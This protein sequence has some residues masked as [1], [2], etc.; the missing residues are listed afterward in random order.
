MASKILVYT[1]TLVLTHYIASFIQAFLH[2]VVAHRKFG[3]ILRKNH[4][5]Y[6]H[7]IYSKNVMVS[8][9][10]IDEEKSLTIY[11]VLP[12]T[13]VA[14]IDYLLLPLDIF[15][16][17]VSALALSFYAHVYVHVQYHLK[18]PWLKRF[19]WFKKK[20]ALHI[21][22]HKNGSKNFA[23]LEFL[24]DRAFGTFQGAKVEVKG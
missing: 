18:D 21:L 23:V 11:Y 17:H 16:I 4:L 15:L 22:H 14:S 5:R 24:W 2:R 7:A 3:G 6:H 20:Q 1:A 19:E 12:A 10:Y 8:E 13:I 9:K